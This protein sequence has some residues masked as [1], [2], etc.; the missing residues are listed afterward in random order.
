MDVAFE[1]T[2]GAII[3]DVNITENMTVSISANM[4]AAEHA[5]LT[6]SA[7]CNFLT[8]SERFSV[9]KSINSHDQRGTLQSST[10]RP[11]RS[12]TARSTHRLSWHSTQY[13]DVTLVYSSFHRASQSP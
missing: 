2:I 12:Q 13:F 3:D 10:L 5:V 8:Y 1:T 9:S 6:R 7:H 4:A 11:C